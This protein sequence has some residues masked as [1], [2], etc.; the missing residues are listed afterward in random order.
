MEWFLAAL[1]NYAVFKGRACR[2][3]FWY[4]LLF[5]FVIGFFFG[6][7][8]A[9]IHR[10]ILSNIYTLAILIPSIAVTVRRF[11]DI[12][13]SGWYTAGFYLLNFVFLV[14]GSFLSKQGLSYMGYIPFVLCYI[15]FFVFMAKDSQSGDNQ[16]GANPKA[17]PAPVGRE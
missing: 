6:M 1:K 16:Y 11:H 13:L 15:V 2:Q 17:L 14:L 4:F 7:I 10:K 9:V 12:G 5:T 3:E 8:D